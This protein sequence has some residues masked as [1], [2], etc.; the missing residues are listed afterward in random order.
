MAR[1]K[2]SNKAFLHIPVGGRLLPL[3]GSAASVSL[4]LTALY[5]PKMVLDCVTAQ[6]SVGVLFRKLFLMGGLWLLLTVV[7]LAL[8]NAITTYAQTRL[9]TRQIPAWE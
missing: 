3:L 6:V 5:L 7:N 2:N 4:S 1:Y 9:Y 8:R